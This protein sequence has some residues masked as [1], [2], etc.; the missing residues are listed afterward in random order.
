MGRWIA[1]DPGEDTGFSIWEDNRLILGTTIKMWSVADV[2]G[3]AVETK[4]P[5]MS[6]DEFTDAYPELAHVYEQ[7]AGY[8]IDRFVVED[9]RIYPWK[10]KEL[11]WDQC[12][13]ARLIGAL[14]YIARVNDIDF[15]LQGAKIKERAVA[16]GAEE[17][18]YKPLHENRH[19]ND[20]IQHAV[21]YLQTELGQAPVDGRIQ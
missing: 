14:T 18:Y 13:T 4:R 10:A 8:P 17:L 15:I 7:L 19:Q 3:E 21:F 1:V 12:R 2:V 6:M 9:W 5:T 11:S 20:S 16:G